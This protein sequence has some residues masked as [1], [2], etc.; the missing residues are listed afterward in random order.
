M[1]KLKVFLNLMLLIVFCS[2]ISSCQDTSKALKLAKTGNIISTQ[3]EP[4]DA[5]FEYKLGDLDQLE[6]KVWEGV[7]NKLQETKDKEKGSPESEEYRISRGDVLIISVWQWDDLNKDVIVR[8][9]GRISFPL[10]GEIIVEGM[11]L[12]ELDKVMTEKLKEY[13]KFPEVSIMVKEFG[14]SKF[15]AIKDFPQQIVV[16][17]DGRISF[18]FIGDIFVRGRT[19]PDVG[20]EIK[21]KL[22]N[23]F[24]SPEVYMNLVRFGGKRVVV[25]GEVQDPGVFMPVNNA[26]VLDVIAMAGGYTKDT[27]LGSVV[28]VRTGPD[29][30]PK[31]QKINLAKIMRGQDLSKNVYVQAEDIIYV[32]RTPITDISY[33][34]QQLLSPLQSSASATS[35]LKT[36]RQRTSPFLYVTTTISP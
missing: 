8:P 35:S 10:V 19:L 22:S 26:R 36:I 21:K 31:A 17:P 15:G 9:D 11:T 5:S 30:K 20:S 29:G 33:F 2:M 3:A 4:I 7:G 12:T 25:L 34:L 18:P 14:K 23:Y 6:I 13:I 28:L 24:A 32:P 1:A 27:A 16:R